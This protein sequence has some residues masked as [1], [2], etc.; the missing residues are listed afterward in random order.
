MN[1]M[2]LIAFAQ[3]QVLETVLS[4]L[5]VIVGKST[6]FE[7]LRSLMSPNVLVLGR[8]ESFASACKGHCLQCISPACLGCL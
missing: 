6:Q 1:E 2:L 5:R 7:R 4:G 8:G 3:C